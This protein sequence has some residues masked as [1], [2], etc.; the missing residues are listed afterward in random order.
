MERKQG[1][2]ISGLMIFTGILIIAGLVANGISYA[3]APGQVQGVTDDTIK[4]GLFGPLTGMAAMYGRATHLTEAIFQ[5]MVN[6]TGGIHGRKI[7]MTSE[8]DGCELV[9]G[10]AAVKKLI[11]QDKVFMLVGGS[12]S[13]VCLAA[14]NEIVAERI[15]WMSVGAA[16][17]GIYY[18]TEKNIFIPQITS[19]L[20]S[21]TIADF[22]M[23]KPGTKRVAIIRHTDEW[24]MSFY[25]PLLQYLKEK[26]NLTPVADVVIERGVTDATPQVLQIKQANPDFIFELI[27]IVPT[28]TFLRDSYKLGLDVPIIGTTAIAV[29][30][31]FKRVGIPEALKNFFSCWWYKYP[32]DSPEMEKWKELLKK[33]Y[34]RDDFDAFSGYGIGGPLIVIEALKKVG[35]NLTREKLIEALEGFSNFST[36]IYPMAYP[37]SFSKTDHIGMKRD[38]ISTIATGKVKIIYKWKEY[39]ELTKGR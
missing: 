2:R 22:A 1:K 16:A 27:Y 10:V 13:N 31:Q 26:Y 37:L 30:E 32:I 38:A 11:Y 5:E 15:P 3:Q 17:R 12:C 39:E 33:Y 36:D 23:T 25:T 9:K 28:S 35:R 34:P 6:K 29:D 4:V 19:D 21:Q 24:S 14:K 20:V 18:P 8:D 7:V